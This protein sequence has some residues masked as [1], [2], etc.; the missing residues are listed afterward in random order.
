[1]SY[2]VLNLPQHYTQTG[3]YYD[4]NY[5]IGWHKLKAQEYTPPDNNY[6]PAIG[7]LRNYIIHFK[8]I[9]HFV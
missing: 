5:T 6:C 3:R 1:M 4:Y 2:H 9:I 7:C 8:H